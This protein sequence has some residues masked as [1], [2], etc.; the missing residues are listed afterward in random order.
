VKPENE[1]CMLHLPM[2][3]RSNQPDRTLETGGAIPV[4]SD[5]ATY[6][7]EWQPAQATMQAALPVAVAARGG[8]VSFTSSRG[9][10]AL[11]VGDTWLVSITG[12]SPNTAVTVSGS[13][14]AGPF[15]GTPMGVTDA[16]GNFSKSGSVGTGEIGPWSQNW[17]VGSQSAGAFSF[18]VSGAPVVQTL[19]IG[20]S[21]Q[22][23]PIGGA[24]QGLPVDAGLPSDGVLGGFS[25]SNIP[26][27]GWAAGLGA[28]VYA[29]GGGSGR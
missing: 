17:A 6:T 7:D 14:P 24:A 8:R 10:N 25:L 21:V 11:R 12:A 29:F 16:A 13:G 15:S 26:W 1:V 22:T 5:S 2:A 18:T 20:G 23:L 19:P 3:A 27:W 28:A 4:R 9:S